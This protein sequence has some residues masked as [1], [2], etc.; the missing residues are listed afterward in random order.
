MRMNR[1]YHENILTNYTVAASR[2]LIALTK[3]WGSAFREEVRANRNEENHLRRRLT[4]VG[5]E[6]LELRGQ[7]DKQD[8]ILRLKH[9][10]EEIKAIITPDGVDQDGLP[11]LPLF[12]SELEIETFDP[13]SMTF[14]QISIHDFAVQN[15]HTYIREKSKKEIAKAETQ[16]KTA[17]SNLKTFK[18]AKESPKKKAKIKRAEAYVIRSEE[19]LATI[20]NNF[21]NVEKMYAAFG[22]YH[23]ELELVRLLLETVQKSFRFKLKSVVE[24]AK[25]IVSVEAAT[26]NGIHWDSLQKVI[27]TAFASYERELQRIFPLIRKSDAHTRTKELVAEGIDFKPLVPRFVGGTIQL[28]LIGLGKAYYEPEIGSIILHSAKGMFPNPLGFTNVLLPG[29]GS[30][31]SNEASWR[32]NMEKQAQRGM[33]AQA[34]ALPMSGPFPTDNSLFGSLYSMD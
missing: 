24:L 27:R 34:I 28:E 26:D 17:Q 15:F 20:K 14:A 5:K 31:F 10:F 33:N 8:V 12:Q 13:V 9:Q 21:E 19:N 1:R 18:E 32:G 29:D 2:Y 11:F 22:P 6:L 4:E 16:L 7:N 23:L 3:N 25:E 30:N